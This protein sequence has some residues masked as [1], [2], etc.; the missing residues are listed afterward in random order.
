MDAIGSS[1][2]TETFLRLSVVLS[3]NNKHNKH[4]KTKQSVRW[5]TTILATSSAAAA[6]PSPQQLEAEIAQLKALLAEKEIC[7]SVPFFL[8]QFVR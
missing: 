3:S 6:A 5:L 2:F 7:T 4:N 1:T 8:I